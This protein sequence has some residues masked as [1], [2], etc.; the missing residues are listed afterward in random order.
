MVGTAIMTWRLTAGE[1]QDTV[2]GPV[3]WRA[4]RAAP[5]PAK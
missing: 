4:F 5:S 2:P 3:R 1:R